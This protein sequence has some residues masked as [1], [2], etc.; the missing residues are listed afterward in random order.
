MAKIRS[1]LAMVA[2][3]DVESKI[4]TSGYLV[5]ASITTKMY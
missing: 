3:T 5:Y 4:S 2:G 1:S